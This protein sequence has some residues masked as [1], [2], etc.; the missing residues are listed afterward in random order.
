MAA[1]RRP[2]GE[3]RRWTLHEYT[4]DVQPV[5][6]SLRLSGQQAGLL[7]L[8]VN[9]RSSTGPQGRSVRKSGPDESGGEE[10]TVQ[11]ITASKWEV[12]G[13]SFTVEADLGGVVGRHGRG[14]YKITIWGN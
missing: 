8:L 10:I 6:F 13:D 12:Q 7:S 4:R 5:S 9:R 14:L 3:G 2:A 1:I 11:W